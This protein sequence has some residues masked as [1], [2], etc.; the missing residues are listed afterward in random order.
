MAKNKVDINKY[1]VLDLK[2]LMDEAKKLKI[3][4]AGNYAKQDLIFEIVKKV[5]KDKGSDI[6][7]NGILDIMSDGYGFLSPI[8]F[9]FTNTSLNIY[10]SQS[11]IKKK[12]L[13]NGDNVLCKVRLKGDGEKYSAAIEILEVNGSVD[14]DKNRPLFDNLIPVYPNERIVLERGQSDVTGRILDLFVPVG[15]GQRALIVAPPKTGKTE[16]LKNIANSISQNNPQ[17]ELKILLVDE[18]PE[19]VTDI[20]KTTSAEVFASTF[21]EPTKK[22]VRLSEQVL[23]RAKRE[24]ELGKDVVILLDSITRLARAYN[25]EIPSS[26]KVLSGGVDAAALHK[27]KRFF[28]AARNIEGGGSL[29]IIATA[30]VDTGSKMDEVIF[31]EFKGTG[32]SEIVL[33]RELSNKRL[34]P[35]IDVIKSGT[36]KE[37]LLFN[38]LE[39]RVSMALRDGFASNDKSYENNFKFISKKISGSKSNKEFYSMIKDD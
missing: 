5:T 11:Q 20:R 8:E 7:F 23:E 1:N 17:A 26:G 39:F 21:D 29:T 6:Y 38:E 36:R 14:T 31:E 27:P 28:G 34:F 22:H 19:E 12:S 35:A 15:F 2:V 13:R 30:L 37:E 3:E 24:V 4:G 33:T 10:V 9:P 18:R 16:M 32:N 25:Q